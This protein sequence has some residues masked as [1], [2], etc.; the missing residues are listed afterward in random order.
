[1][2][3]INILLLGRNGNGKSSSGNSI[4]GK[5]VFTP[6]GAS[7]E[8]VDEIL[9]GSLII[10]NKEINVVEGPGLGDASLDDH[11]DVLKI[12]QNVEAALS[13]CP[14][15]FIA[16]I[17]VLKYGVRYT[18]QE[19]DVVLL[20]KDI[21]GNNILSDHGVILMTH[22]D[23]FAADNEDDSMTFKD[24]CEEQTGDMRELMDECEK[25]YV[26]FN[27]REK[28]TFKIRVQR[29]MLMIEIDKILSSSRPYTFEN[30][31]QAEAGRKGLLVKSKL[32]SLK[33]LQRKF[34]A[35]INQR[36]A[37]IDRTSPDESIIILREL[38]VKL[39][40]HKSMLLSEAEDTN[41]MDGLLQ[42]LKLSEQSVSIKMTTANTLIAQRQY[43][44][45]GDRHSTGSNESSSIIRDRSSHRDDCW[46]P[47]RDC[48]T[49]SIMCIYHGARY[50]FLQLRHMLSGR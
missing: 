25:R 24:W 28:D 41:L 27:N 26:L 4:L 37:R 17:F 48:F 34:L 15:G 5:K 40:S 18:R 50:I 33:D 32:P 23:N 30:F 38:Q 39:N 47:V 1:M 21:F 44:I 31:S 20:I 43:Q 13:L 35:E 19:K 49:G 2:Q 9:K 3:K 42:E 22:G 10:D 6:R 16:V 14:D 36:L 11:E 45:D 46:T 12:F 7:Q 29:D 8:S